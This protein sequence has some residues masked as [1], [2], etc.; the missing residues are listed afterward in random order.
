MTQ[1][2]YENWLHSVIDEVTPKIAN[3]IAMALANK[4]QTVKSQD[5]TNVL[6]N[7]VSK[8]FLSICASNDLSRADT[9]ESVQ[10]FNGHLMEL[11]ERNIGIY[12]KEH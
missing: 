3:I 9:M 1:S 7:A 6:A 5:L 12:I 10:F 8:M 4:S 2:E 11:A